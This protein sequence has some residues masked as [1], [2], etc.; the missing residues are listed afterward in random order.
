[1]QNQFIPRTIK[2]YGKRIAEF[3]R[4]LKEV[5][6]HAV[7]KHP[8]VDLPATSSG[9]AESGTQSQPRQELSAFCLPN[10]G[11]AFTSEQVEHCLEHARQGN[12]EAQHALSLLYLPGGKL[13]ADEHEFFK[14]SRLAAQQDHVEAVIRL[15]RYYHEGPFGHAEKSQAYQWWL[16]AANLGSA[17]AQTSLAIMLLNG[18]ILPSDLYSDISPTEGIGAGDTG[19]AHA[20]LLRAAGQ[21]YHEAMFHLGRMYERGLQ[22]PRNT[23][24]AMRWYHQAAEN[25]NEKA[26][27]RITVLANL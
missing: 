25:G 19:N 3:V 11:E 18:E 1:M 21:G 22:V 24:E 10:A 9:L 8:G 17:R 4:L 2:R 6:S 14:W 26:M 16:K 5:V 15:A 23:Q 27:A 7:I 20:W 13:G 12:A